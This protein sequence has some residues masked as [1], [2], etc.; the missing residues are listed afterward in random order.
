MT[1]AKREGSHTPQ[2][3]R[4][5]PVI[6]VRL[7][8]YTRP[9]T[10]STPPAARSSAVMVNGQSHSAAASAAQTAPSATVDTRC[11]AHTGPRT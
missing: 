2:K 4:G 10:G 3:P 11:Q 1:E 5:R 8:R 7:R 6:R 9:S